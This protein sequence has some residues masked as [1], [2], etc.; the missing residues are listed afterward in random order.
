MAVGEP[1]RKQA[2]P[3]LW[4][5][6]RK[7]VALIGPPLLADEVESILQYRLYSGRAP[8][9]AVD[10]SLAAFYATG[11]RFVTHPD[12]VRRAREMARQFHQERIYDSL[13]AA[14]AELNDSEFWTADRAFDEAVSPALADVRYLPNYPLK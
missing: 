1:F 9:E 11:I 14:L 8:V 4:D 6:R 2:R 12:M 13:Y 10:A 5:T 3:L 7:G